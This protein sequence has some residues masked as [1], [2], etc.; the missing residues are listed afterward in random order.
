MHGFDANFCYFQ[1]SRNPYVL[2]ASLYDDYALEMV[3]ILFKGRKD[4]FSNIQPGTL[5]RCLSNST[6]PYK[7]FILVILDLAAPYVNKVSKKYSIV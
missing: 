2:V 1:L 6:E 5:M 4:R 3:W 7:L